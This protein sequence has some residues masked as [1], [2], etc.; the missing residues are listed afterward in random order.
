MRE[1]GAPRRRR[2]FISLRVHVR[3]RGA[4]CGT[5]EESDELID[6]PID[7]PVDEPDELSLKLPWRVALRSCAR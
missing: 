1:L 5:R 2:R 6:E 3:R 7:E 4:R